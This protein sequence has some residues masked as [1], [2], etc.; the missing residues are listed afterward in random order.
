MK[1]LAFALITL[2]LMFTCTACGSKDSG[3]QTTVT[4]PSSSVLNVEVTTAPVGL[5]PLKTNDAA[6]TYVTAQIYET[7]YRRT[8]DGKEFVPCLAS[9][10]PEY[11]DDGLTAIIPLREGVTFSDGTPFTADAVAYVFDCMKDKS[12]G[13]QRPSIVDSIESYEVIDDHH[14]KLHLAYKDGVL[15]AKLAHTNGSIVNPAKDKENDL[16]VNPEGAGTGAY[17]YVSSVSGSTYTLEANENYWGGAPEV[18]TVNFAVVGDEATAV[19]RLQTGEADFYPTVAVDSFETLKNSA[20]VKA[21]SMESSAVGYMALRSSEAEAKNPLMANKDFRKAVL[22]AVDTD[23]FVTSVMGTQGETLKSIIAP[24]LVGYTKA[25]ED[26]CVGYNPEDAKKVIE[27]NGWTGQTVTMLVPTRDLQQTFAA[28]V[29]SQLQA[30]GLNVE[31]VS[32]EWASFLTS[33]KGSKNFDITML[34]WSNV[35]GDGEQMLNPNFSSN[36]GVRVKYNNPEFDA[37]VTA[38]AQT[39]VLAER[40]AHMLKAVEIIQGDAVVK[41]IFTQNS[42][43]AYN[44]NKVATANFAVE[45][46]FHVKDFKL[47]K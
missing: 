23:T 8:D 31:I 11:S 2:S 22:E 43:Y 30:V 38:S 4:D 24:S 45:T 19:A 6:S 32:E 27:E 44:S 15:I 20:G 13:A 40:E 1:K 25:M 28:Y 37:E 26:S 29:Q 34:S 7:L 16:L 47:V 17:K 33:A 39:T 3:G 5:H 10:L 21:E 41:P 35:T 36:N 12:Y 46:L 18:K 9:D 14:I 42:L